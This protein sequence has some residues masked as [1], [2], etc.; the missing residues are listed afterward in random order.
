MELSCH[1]ARKIP[2][3]LQHGQERLPGVRVRVRVCSYP[4]QQTRVNL[5]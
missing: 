1:S 4:T 3:H 2:Q 5:F